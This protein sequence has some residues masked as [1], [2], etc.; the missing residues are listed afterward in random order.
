MSNGKCYVGGCTRLIDG[1]CSSCAKSFCRAHLG[2]VTRRILVYASP[3]SYYSHSS[4]PLVFC[5][6]CWENERDR[7]ERLFWAV[8]IGLLFFA[9]FF[10][11]V[12]A[13]L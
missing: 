4:V 9:L 5:A 10:Q 6:E 8:W 2:G 13:I 1:R 3:I 12:V 11:A 7:S